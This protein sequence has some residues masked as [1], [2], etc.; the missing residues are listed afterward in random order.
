[1]RAVA[2]IGIVLG[3]AFASGAAAQ[4]PP[5]D[6]ISKA[7]QEGTVVY[8]T[9]LIVDQIVSIRRVRCAPTCSV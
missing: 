4:E 1:M 9:D 5:A 8:Y 6:L 3:L 7:K 2:G